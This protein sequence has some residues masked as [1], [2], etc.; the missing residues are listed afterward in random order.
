M[1]NAPKCHHTQPQRATTALLAGFLCAGITLARAN[2]VTFQVNMGVQ[3]VLGNFDPADNDTVLVSGDFS[4]P[5]WTTTLVLMPSGSEANLYVGT[6][7]NDRPTGDFGHHKFI[8]NPGG[9]S[10]AGQLIWESGSDRWFQ[11][12]AGD[13]TLP[14]V[15]FDGVTN[16]PAP[17][18]N[19]PIE[20][21]AGADMS[22]AAFFEDRGITYRADGQPREVFD[23]LREGGFNCVRLRLFTSSAA[24]AAGDPYNY[25]NNL[26]YTVP[27]A[28]RVKNAGLKFLLD[29]HYS[30]SWADPGKQNKPSAWTNLSFAELEQQVRDYSSNSVAAFKSAG[31]MPDYVQVGNEITSGMLWPDGQV[32]GNTNTS[33]S[34]L[35]TLLKAA[36]SGIQDAAAATPPQIIVHIDRGGDWSTTRWYFD[37]LE[38]QQVPYDIIGQSYYPWWH[39]DLNA[40]RICLNNT[41]VRYGKPVMVMETAFPWTTPSYD[42]NLGIPRTP[43]GQMEYAVALAQIIKDLPN[44]MGAGI[45]WWGSEYVQ[46]SGYNL[47]GFHRTS[48]FDYGGNVHPVVETL[49]QLTA[50]VAL[51]ADL[52][53]GQLRLQWPLS[54]AG[55]SLVT[56]TSPAPSTLWMEVL[57]PVS[58]LTG[59]YQTTVP[60]ESVPQRLYRLESN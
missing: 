30:D 52:E 60:L 51:R 18:T 32:S 31:A 54:G 35:G 26:D 11:V 24:Q 14:V 3:R 34:N 40:L 5:D 45:F 9:N 37:N 27:L 55:L 48:F 39:G 47:A 12:E 20:F 33:W 41:S 6:F 13:Q 25:T 19:S 10:S 29:F 28:V 58:N 21:L 16:L 15:Y 8:I 4:T 50:E 1:S 36:I 53:S 57:N 22:H 59:T 42:P 38:F 17:P 46:L 23:V 2:Q 56:T 44:G 49:G 43:E 7:D